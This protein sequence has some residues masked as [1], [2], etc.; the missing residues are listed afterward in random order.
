V[1]GRTI[2]LMAGDVRSIRVESR[3][4]T[5]ALIIF[6]QD[7]ERPLIEARLDLGDL[8]EL[9]EALAENWFA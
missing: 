9:I 8:D 1:S 5:V 6:D 3:G 4:A 7:G 2:T